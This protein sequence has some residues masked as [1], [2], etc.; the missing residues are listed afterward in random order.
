MTPLAQ[1]SNANCDEKE[2]TQALP[3]MAMFHFTSL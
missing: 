3:A 2:D 1:K